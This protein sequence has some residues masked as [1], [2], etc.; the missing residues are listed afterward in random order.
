MPTSDL[1][2][3]EFKGFLFIRDS[4]R[5]RGRTPTLQAISDH[6]GFKSRRSAALLIERLTKKGYVT[7]AMNGNLRPVREVH[8]S[9]ETERTVK[10]PL[11][12]TA[13]CGLPLLAEENVE[14]M[15]PVSQR[16]ARPGAV[17]FLLRA[18]G[19]S[20]DQAG[21]QDGD[22][23]LVRQQPVAQEGERIVALIDDE[24]TIKEYRQRGDQII[25]TPRSKNSVH[26]PIILERNFMIQGVV[27]ATVQKIDFQ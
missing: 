21:I 8:E 18:S 5:Y 23:V 14:A 15:I 27:I 7:R 4:I 25:L 20:M 24:A 17:Y 9:A 11:V 10:I 6:L 12:G 16:I 3:K 1:S 19:D 13:P 2:P 22:L 26:K